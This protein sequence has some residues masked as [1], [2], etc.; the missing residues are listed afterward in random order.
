MVTLMRCPV[1]DRLYEATG[2][3]AAS[4]AFCEVDGEKLVPERV[5]APTLPVAPPPASL[6]LLEEPSARRVMTEAT[7]LSPEALEALLLELATLAERFDASGLAWQ[8]LPED[9]AI[10]PDGRLGLLHA[11]GVY[12][13][14]NAVD[15][16]GPLRAL[17]EALAGAAIHRA[18]TAVVELVSDPRLPPMNA[19]ALRAR[20]TE[21]SARPQP[22]G[23]NAATYLHLGYRRDKQDDAVAAVL[24]T[25]GGESF[26]GMVLCDGISSSA[27]G[28][29]AANV[30]VDAVSEFFRAA[31][32]GTPIS[33]LVEQSIARAQ[34]AV[35]RAVDEKMPGEAPGTTIV[36]AILEGRSLAVAW[37]GDSRAYVIGTGNGRLLTRDHSWGNE[38]LDTGA[39]A[40]EEAFAQPLALALT[41]YVGPSDPGEPPL[42]IEV[43]LTTVDSG[44][45]VVLC[46][47]GLW[48]YAPSAEELGVLVAPHRNDAVALARA[49]V[50]ETLLRGAHDNV[51]VAV[52]VVE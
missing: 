21:A 20:L 2:D 26:L 6:A 4:T 47:D 43:A 40:F 16:R 37:A 23:R 48:S 13:T 12:R 35:M 1:C 5:L 45:V 33:E 44:D 18:P 52:C 17:G 22:A 32:P 46:S 3:D 19:A 7:S 8:P 10:G 25:R 11:R 51:S 28:A 38:M 50:H 30:A 49:L 9:F 42:A 31:P 29:F 39:V 24:G 14:T 34:D 27:D 41:R 36:A 15:V